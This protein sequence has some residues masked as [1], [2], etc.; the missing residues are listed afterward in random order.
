MTN[1]Q[2]FLKVP[3]VAEILKKLSEREGEKDEHK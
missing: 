3:E 1:S 2:P